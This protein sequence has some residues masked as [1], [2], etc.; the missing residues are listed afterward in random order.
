MRDWNID[1]HEW[2]AL[3]PLLEE[4]LDLP[5]SR[6]SDWLDNLAPQFQ[7]LKPRLRE[8]LSRVGLPE[9]L[10]LLETIPKL[11]TD[12]TNERITIHASEEQAGD[13]VG[14]YRL[15]RRLAEGGMGVVWLG[16]RIDGMINRPV[17]LKL[18]HSTSNA[19]S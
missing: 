16:E 10:G 3:N 13:A 9:C 12:P 8:L 14:P 5:V 18:P 4:A 19:R 6:R 15:I 11:D 7:R 17:A 2:N 1:L